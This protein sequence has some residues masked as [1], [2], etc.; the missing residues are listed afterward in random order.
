[1]SQNNAKQAIDFVKR[2]GVNS[3]V[4]IGGEPTCYK[5][6]FDIVRYCSSGGMKVT[7]PTNGIALS[8]RSYLNNLLSCGVHRIGLSLKGTD[9]LSYINNTGIDSFESVMN[10]IHNLSNANANFGVSFVLDVNNCNSFVNGFRAAKEQGADN[11]SLSFCYEFNCFGENKNINTPAQMLQ[12]SIDTLNALRENYDELHALT[13]GR[14]TISQ[15]L[16]LCLWDKDF[17]NVLSNRHQ[18]SSICQLLSGTGIL[19]DHELNLIPCNAMYRVK[20]G[21]LGDD[22]STPE[23]L[24]EHLKSPEI[25]ALFSRLRGVPDK[26]CSNCKSLALCGGG[27]ISNWTNYSIEDIISIGH[28][29]EQ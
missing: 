12:D 6:L 28:Y 22:F 1:M 20:F 15:S 24:E 9:R 4:L 10:A 3:I 7:I 26:I 29:N 13:N 23:E 11:F 14:L 17:V 8:D 5:G 21:K 2:L 25:V 16:P 19:F 27:C 18:L